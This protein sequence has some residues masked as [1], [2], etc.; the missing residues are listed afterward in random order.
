MAQRT[1]REMYL[2]MAK[3]IEPDF[4]LQYTYGGNPYSDRPEI[5]SGCFPSI[6]RG[7]RGP[8]GSNK[9][10]WGVTYVA[11]KEAGYAGLPEPGNFILDD[12]TKWRDVIKA[13]D[14][15]HV[16]WEQLAKKDM[17]AAVYTR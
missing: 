3:G 8:G 4:L 1:M 11:N 17:A 10:I 13:P 9:D 12:I 16:D 6:L 7:D 14:L 2:D 15:S 5:C